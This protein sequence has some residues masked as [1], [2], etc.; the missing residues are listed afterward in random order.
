MEKQTIFFVLL[1]CSFATIFANPNNWFN[2]RLDHFNNQDLTMW[3]QRYL[4]NDTF[5]DQSNEFGGP[6]FGTNSLK[7]C[8]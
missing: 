7:F 8:C 6:I 3:K 5:W 2:Q 1:A 4:V